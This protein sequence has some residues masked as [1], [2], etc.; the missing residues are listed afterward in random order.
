MNS[1]NRVLEFLLWCAMQTLQCRT[2]AVTLN[3]I[4][5]EDLGGGH[6]RWTVVMWTLRE[7]Q[8]LEG[9]RDARRAVGY[10]SQFTGAESKRPIGLLSMSHQL[11]SRLHLGCTTDSFTRALF[12]KIVLVAAAKS[13]AFGVDFWQLCVLNNP[14]DSE[15]IPSMDG[16]LHTD[17]APLEAVGI[18]PLLSVSLASG[19][20]SLRYVYEAW[21]A[22]SIN[23]AMIIDIVDL[24]YCS[25]YLSS[26]PGFT[27]FTSSRS[28]LC[29]L[30]KVSYI[31]WWLRY[32]F[33][34][35]FSNQAF[36]RSRGPWS[37]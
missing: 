19:I 35:G 22:G 31:F 2:K 37:I 23:R 28:K 34:H 32:S 17:F 24:D 30:W 7:I 6:I 25:A 10:F 12:R 27:L 16:G 15:L 3:V 36:S 4:F 8:L 13:I 14:L 5:P 29:S 33:S 20:G 26:S 18:S 21:K 11:R 9:I 1:A